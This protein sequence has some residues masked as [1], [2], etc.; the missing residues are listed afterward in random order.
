MYKKIGMMSLVLAMIATVLISCG[1][2]TSEKDAQIAE[3]QKQ[4][5]NLQQQVNQNQQTKQTT[6]QTTAQQTA[7]QQ[8]VSQQTIPQQAPIQ[9]GYSHGAGI[10]PT[11]TIDQA[12]EIATKDA[13][14]DINSV[15]FI[16]TMQDYDDGFLY[17]EIDFVANGNKYEYDINAT[18]GG[19]SKKQVQPIEQGTVTQQAIPQNAAGVTQ[20]QG[21][22][23]DQAKQIAVQQ[24]GFDIASVTF[25]KQE[26]DFEHG[27]PQW[28]IEF[29][30]GTMKYEYEI[31]ATTGAVTKSKVESIYND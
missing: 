9:G 31:S 20:G 25:V 19:M 11:I 12:K 14:V 26:Y 6:Q 22:T 15:T 27:M 30:S 1:G 13:G 17:W 16:K 18:T 3:M 23:V 4:L 7:P 2:N 21:I 8:A 10:A 29:V 5:E 28:E 24:A